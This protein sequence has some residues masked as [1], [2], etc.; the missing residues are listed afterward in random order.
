MK[1][2]LMIWL[3]LIFVTTLCIILALGATVPHTTKFM[4]DNRCMRLD[5]PC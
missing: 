2:D 1:K 3:V 4:R 5:V